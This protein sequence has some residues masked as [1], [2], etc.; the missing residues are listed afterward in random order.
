MARAGYGLE[1]GK[2]STSEMSQAQAI[3]LN[4]DSFFYGHAV[5]ASILIPFT[6]ERKNNTIGP[7]MYLDY[8]FRFTN[9][10]RG[11]HYIGIKV[12]L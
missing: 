6:K 1:I 8:A 10:W 3:L 9:H 12:T 11:N 5:G 2:R 7:R 4:S